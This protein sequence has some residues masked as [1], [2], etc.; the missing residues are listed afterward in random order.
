MAKKKD[1]KMTQSDLGT[2]CSR[3]FYQSQDYMDVIQSERK[4][5]LNAYNQEPYGNEEDGLSKFISTDVRDTIEWIMPQLVD[6][7]VGGD[8]PVIF[9]PQNDQDT[10]A[11]ETESDYCQYI[12]LRQ[13]HGAIITSVWFKDALLQKN[14]IIKCY[15]RD[16]VRIEREEYK[17]KTGQDY[18]ALQQDD[19][20]EIEE[21]TITVNE[22]EYDE[23]EYGRILQAITDPQSQAAIENDAR[24]E[25]IG[26]R[27]K[28]VGQVVIEN[29]PP[30]NF[31]VQRGHPSI[32]LKDAGYC[33]EFEEKTRSE[34]VEEGYDKDLV[35]SLPSN[36]EIVNKS[37]E[38]ATRFRKEG[39]QALSRSTEFVDKSR[40]VI[41]VYNHFIRADFNN[42]GHAE[43]RFVRTVGLNGEHV[44][45]NEEVDRNIYHAITPYINSHKFFG[46][47]IAD[48]L[49]DLQKAKSQLWR[50]FFDNAMYSTL[51]RKIISGNVD[52]DALLSYVPGGVVKKDLNATVENDVVPFV[53][54][55][56]MPLMDRLDSA[57][58][59]RTGFS[60]DAAG[61][62]PAA[63][64]NSTNMV[65]MTIMAQSQLLIKMIAT[66]FANSGYS[67]MMLNI[68]ELLMKYE[69]Q[70]RIFQLS[71]AFMKANP[72]DWR[73]QRTTKVRV[74]IGYAGK[75]EM[76][77]ML[78]GIFQN[79]T[80]MVQ[81]QQGANGPMVNA[82]GIYNVQKHMLRLMGITDCENY[83]QD[84]QTYQPPAPAPTLAE[85]GLKANIDDMKNK[86]TINQAD[87]TLKVKQMDQDHELNLAKLTQAE[88]FHAQE[89]A[90]KAEQFDKEL[91]YKYGSDA[92]ASAARV[93]DT[94]H[95]GMIDAN[96]STAN[97]KAKN[98]QAI[99]PKKRKT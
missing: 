85:I 37:D 16:Q 75:V 29:V 74:G 41:L 73:T 47:S 50:N 3:E 2:L 54:G 20:Y 24:Y 26:H 13:N 59:E 14:G 60:R 65:A 78:N 70:E 53:S 33:C 9:E 77:S 95:K 46:R 36:Q 42:D 89:L 58:A 93:A 64:A 88:R 27:K 1:P 72:R 25:I 62:D 10:A 56:V 84:P 87:Q 80:L 94:A 12:F 17:N 22:K 18:L 34:L 21:V 57:R 98:D 6:I 81:A 90:Q 23:A 11:A 66:I 99:E 5:S 97:A 32:F 44:L 86:T 43:L 61:L 48:N 19:E 45:E 68:R 7:F 49:R 30:E 92:H 82:G 69:K 76:L 40:E 71:G 51:P 15:W 35:W 67:D 8:T 28:N 96:I 31:V 39:G 83:F 55:E 91:I 79:Q 63:L 38:A 52:V 4:S